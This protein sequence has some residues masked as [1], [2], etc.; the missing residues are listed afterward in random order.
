MGTAAALIGSAIIGAGS[1]ALASKSARSQQKGAISAQERAQERAIFEGTIDQFTP[2]GSLRHGSIDPETGEFVSNEGTKTVQVSESP[3]Q[4]ALR[5]GQQRIRANQQR[6]EFQGADVRQ[7]ALTQFQNILGTGAL[8]IDQAN[9]PGIRSADAIRGILP[10]A[11]GTKEGL[12]SFVRPD[13]FGS[14]IERVEQATFEGVRRKLDPVFRERETRLEQRLSDIGI[15]RG[16]AAFE[17]E[18]QKLREQE[19]EA[20]TRAGLS[21]VS[22]GRGEQERIS[23]LGLATRGQAFG[24]NRAQLQDALQKQLSLTGLELQ[25][26]QQLASEQQVGRQGNLQLANLLANIG[27]GSGAATGSGL[28]FQPLNL[29][30]PN[31]PQF[32]FPQLGSGGVNALSGLS[33]T[34]GTFAGSGGF[35]GNNQDPNFSAGNAPVPTFKPSF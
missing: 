4:K 31:I 21:S 6:A 27:G 23:R 7:N 5:E 30:S 35:E 14:E 22:V 8:G 3:E 9:L 16:S 11:Q 24:E 13:Q 17:R 34:L 32:G 1:S 15:P 2:F 18:I 29:S 28:G 26:R 19:D 33:S 20:L 10:S 25:T 12:P